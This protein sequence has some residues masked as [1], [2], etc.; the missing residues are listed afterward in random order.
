MAVEGGSFR[1]SV[2]SGFFWLSA[3]TFVG[4]FISWLSTIVVIRLLSPSDYGLMAMTTVFISLLTM[5]SEMGI[6][7]ALIQAKE[8]S[9]SEIRQIFGWILISGFIAVSCCYAGAPLVARFYGQ[10][11]LIPLIRFLAV[12]MIL[13]MLYVIPQSL[14]VREM[15]FKTKARIDVSAQLVGALMT[16]T[17]ALN[18]RGVWSLVAGQAAMYLVKAIAFN[19]SGSYRLT[20]L[21][22]FR[23]SWRL[24]RFGLAVTG[25]RLLN[26]IFNE[27]DKIIVGR[28]L[29]NAILGVY[30]VALN[31]AALPM[32]KVLPIVTQISFTS[33][34]RIQSDLER[35]GRNL[36]R[37][38]RTV[39]LAGFPIFFGM[40]AIAPFGIP[41]IL[42]P[43]WEGV[44]VPFQMMCL[45]LPL[46]ALS[47]ILSPA[48]FAIGRPTVNLIN[49]AITAGAM[50]ISFMIGV[51]AGVTG[52]CWAW[53]SVY[54]V[55][56]FI[57]TTRSLNAVGIPFRTY[58][59][60][61]RFP[62]LAG[63]LMLAFIQFL[64]RVVA[65]PGPLFSLV[66][67]I[68]TG[69]AFYICLMLIFKREAYCEIKTLLQR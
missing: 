68:I 11:D 14:L 58:L 24:L 5:S 39:S 21:F 36:L 30:A 42:G 19:V 17:M 61:I 13:I 18:E 44:I 54:P 65:T 31:L 43:K 57:T 16:L 52:V 64:G 8:L 33:Y 56:F 26:F 62:F 29:G 35:I 45:I 10:P 3:A 37:A 55:V 12:N 46:K 50:A 47:P 48:V 49:M 2:L 40:A 4:Q 51:R 15:N 59:A 1:K 27:S 25:D 38:T 41:L 63:A 67:F 9:E 23:G 69:S 20:P 32:E 6:S 34:A 22:S 66:L 7:A 60:E 28:F 53:V